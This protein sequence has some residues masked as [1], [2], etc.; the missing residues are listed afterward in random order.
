MGIVNATPDSFS[1]AHLGDA[2]E[3]GL[4]LLDEG[5]DLLDVGGES[6]RP[7]AA[8]VCEDEELARVVPVIAGLAG[9]AAVSVDTTR[10]SVAQAAVDAG[11]VLVNDVSGGL[12][13]PQMLPFVAAAGVPYVAMHWRGHSADMQTRAVY[14]DVVAEVCAELAARRDAALALDVDV[15]LDPGLGFAKDADHSWALLQRLDAL[16]ALGRPLLVG[17][18]R[19]AFLGALLDKPAAQRDAATAAV[20]VLAAQ[21][22][23]W[24]VRVHDVA[25]SADAV[26]VVA[27]VGS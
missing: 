16:T 2:V 9:R 10:A 20:T 27:R 17:A 19:K 15:V 25:P 11:A 1:D 12:A 18:S 26:R 21:A 7:G 14:D 13:D 23:A 24:A 8:R 6:T 22:G 4:R 3:H 5:A